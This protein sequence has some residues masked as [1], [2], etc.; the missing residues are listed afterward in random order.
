M[1][2]V[3]EGLESLSVGRA[4]ES[5][6]A[7]SVHHPLYR[8]WVDVM[9]K[10]VAELA[11]A[12]GAMK[13]SA[14]PSFVMVTL[15]TED[16]SS[17]AEMFPE[18]RLF[19]YGWARPAHALFVQFRRFSME[20]LMLQAR[21][22]ASSVVVYGTTL[23]SAMQLGF[24]KVA[25]VVDPACPI[26][27]HERYGASMDAYRLY[28]D[29]VS[30]STDAGVVLRRDIY[31][32][33]LAGGDIRFELGDAHASVGE[34]LCVDGWLY[35]YSPM[36][37]AL[38]MVAARASVSL[39]FF[40]YH[41][42][43]LMN[44]Q[45]EIPGFGV[46]YS[47]DGTDIS[48]SY[49]EGLAG[50]G[51]YPLSVWQAWLVSHSFCIGHGP[52]ARWFQLELL[53][54]RG[55]AM[56][57]RMVAIDQEPEV[58]AIFHALDLPAE[59]KS[60]V[61]TSWRLRGLGRDPSRKDSWVSECYIVG[62]RLADRVYQFAMQLP[63]EQFTRYAVRKQLRITNDRIVI[64]GTSVKVNSALG[65]KMLDALVADIFTRA[66]VDRFQ[67]G[68]L[69]DDAR[70]FAESLAGF[71]SASWAERAW[72]ILTVGALSVWEFTIAPTDRYVRNA[73][74]SVRAYLSGGHVVHAPTVT[75]T[76]SYVLVDGSSKFVNLEGGAL[77][78][79]EVTRRA[80]M[81]S[82]GCWS[83]LCRHVAQ[84]QSVVTAPTVHAFKVSDFALFTTPQAQ[85]E[86]V[87]EAIQL[88]RALNPVDEAPHV[89]RMLE[90][91]SAVRALTA[92]RDVDFNPV[93]DPVH[94]FNEAHSS[95]FPG[96][97]EQN[98]EYDTASVSLDPQDRTLAAPYLRLP[99]YFGDVPK[100]KLLYQ[101]KVR[102]LNVPKRQ[103]TL[104]ELLSATAARNLNAPQIALPQSDEAMAIEVWENFLGEMCVPEARSMLKA[105]QNDIVGL[106]ESAFR[107][108]VT[109]STPEKLEAVKR[110]L[111]EKSEALAEMPVDE[112]LVMLK[113]DVKPSLSR[114][115][116]DTRTEPQVIVYHE[117]ALSALYSSIF[118]VLVNRFLALLKPNI[119]VNLKKDMKDIQ[120]FLQGGVHPFGAQG[121]QYLENDFSKYDK[122]Q[123]RFVFILEEY[124]FKQLGMNNE[125]LARWVGGHVECSMRSL[126]LALSL[127]VIYQRKS[128]DATTAFGNTMLNIVSTAYAHKGTKIVW[129][130]YMGDDSLA[131]TLAIAHE[132]DAISILAEVFN[133]SAKTYVT[134]SPYFASNFV[135][136]DDLNARAYLVPD[137]VK[138]IERW[139]MMVSGDDP[140]W[141][142]RYVS[143]CDALSTYLN[144]G[145][146]AL[147]PKMVCERYQVT[148][149]F[150]KGLADA[151]AT[152]LSDERK[153]R[154]MWEEL[155][156]VSNY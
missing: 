35:A 153:F 39:G 154:S 50:V 65:E 51:S 69:S 86:S 57:Y 150:V 123:S 151:V 33:F 124:I 83:Q 84:L 30:A 145:K 10:K 46:Y 1:S 128:G 126:A 62:Q 141:H 110:E 18:F 77:A 122:S 6:V 148:S 63:R 115:P 55:C 155:P 27:I 111:I 58:K 135:I 11:S 87:D 22:L 127:H 131:C 142:E 118:R 45:G 143:A 113:A 95:V 104:Q 75:V 74:D 44:A 81:E 152:V 60:Y 67:A 31:D 32:K 68:N 59:Q 13:S 20:W 25:L 71:S 36:Q 138:R 40:P 103:Q 38:Q 120:Q 140:Q 42:L 94:V 70:R 96:V 90:V 147:L 17:L 117:K 132:T 149:E 14:M 134:H 144:C 37:V 34:A 119:H 41:P 99:R 108:W 136:L 47:R 54:H 146:T 106:E 29:Y 8:A 4:L 98:L 88:M 52:S 12:R 78:A 101:S 76:P 121:L 133:L 66:Y 21:R 156:T 61:F 5:N 116:L 49:P 2:V 125:F 130:L 73:L 9:E 109:Q 28:R 102:A 100:P 89:R 114:K 64:E 56:F 3:S 105:Y 91:A 15:N 53:K 107:E 16:M 97:A 137:P 92:E 93:A 48:F 23:V 43:M 82:V 26:A 72:T 85:G 139:S 112:Y 79:M 24:D 80:A 19:N 129:A 7:L